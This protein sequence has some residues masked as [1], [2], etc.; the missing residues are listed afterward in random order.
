[1]D[2]DLEKEFDRTGTNSIKWEFAVEDEALVEWDRTHASHGDD[3]VLPLWIA[4]MDFPAAPPI[5]AAIR[6]RAEHGV[7][8]YASK[9]KRY[10]SAVASWMHR[11]HGYTVE[12]EWIVPTPGV[13]PGLH[14]CVRRFTEPGDKIVIQPPVYHPFRYSI[15][16]NQRI[17]ANNPL[18]LDHG[19]YRMDFVQLEQTCRDPAVKL[20]ILCSPHNP[21]GRVW[22]SDEL[23]R[24]AEICTRHDVM[25]IADEIHGDL[26]MPDHEFVS[27]GT[28]DKSLT[29]NVVIGTAPSKSFNLAGLQTANLII[30]NEEL[31]KELRAEMSATG[32]FTVN[33]F[34]IAATEAAYN[35]GEPWLE[36][37]ISHI[38]ANLDLL[39]A[40]VS[41]HIPKLRVIR[42][43]GTYLAWVDCRALGLTG[44]ALNSLMMDKAKIYLD[45][46][47]VFG[48]E[49][50][51]FMR[52]N[53]ACSRSI[54]E[55]ALARVCREVGRLAK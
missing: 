40:Y 6:K 3:R 5:Q 47:D 18:V 32:L 10:L 31:R 50:E 35:E 29:E 2:W 14:L 48:D 16:R 42:P 26:I 22:S 8:G 55:T 54:L 9:G 27:Y 25:V 13:V 21:V 11:R 37:V 46:G 53:V 23:T 15:E 17:V 49:G 33:P 30:R 39:E 24:F 28:L 12:Q 7:F 34:G 19:R 20:A 4:D 51:G 41:E 45:R 52:F 38:A 43:E 44:D 36:A 1:M